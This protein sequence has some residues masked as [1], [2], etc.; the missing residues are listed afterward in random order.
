[1][2][3]QL[4]LLD[5]RWN[6]RRQIFVPPTERIDPCAYNVQPVATAAARAFVTAPSHRRR[7]CARREPR[8][9]AFTFTL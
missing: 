8:N 3:E 7:A 4:P 9:L 5:K 6:R 1:M 2:I